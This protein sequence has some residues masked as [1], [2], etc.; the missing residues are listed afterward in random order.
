MIKFEKDDNRLI[1]SYSPSSGIKWIQ[2]KLECDGVVLIKKVF[3]FSRNDVFSNASDL[4]ENDWEIKFLIG[5][6]QDDN[7]YYINSNLLDTK[8]FVMIHKDA[9]IVPTYFGLNK[10]INIIKIFEEIANSQIIIGGEKENSIPIKDYEELIKKF[11]TD[12]E[13]NIM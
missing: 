13:K 7:Y 2:E 9:R 11:P 5:Y 10:R 1:L 12:T 3:C 8:Q 4:L 6:L